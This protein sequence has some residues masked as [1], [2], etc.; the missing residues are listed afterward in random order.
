MLNNTKTIG[1]R[2]VP[3]GALSN[4][5]CILGLLFSLGPT[6]RGFIP[7]NR[8][9]AV[10]IRISPSLWLDWFVSSSRTGKTPS[11]FPSPPHLSFSLLFSFE[12]CNTL[13]VRGIRI[14]CYLAENLSESL[15]LFCVVVSNKRRCEGYRVDHHFIHW[16]DRCF[17]T[18]VTGSHLVDSAGKLLPLVHCGLPFKAAALKLTP[19]RLRF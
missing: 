9:T 6:P 17:R 3:Q 14:W 7:V 8:S 18:S 2:W 16:P 5:S 19:F 1:G 11:P 13:R 12:N 10:V 4:T 15:F